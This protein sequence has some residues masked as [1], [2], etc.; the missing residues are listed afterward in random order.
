MSVRVETEEA[1]D[2]KE[3]EN[4][5]Q[6]LAI[7]LEPEVNDVEEILADHPQDESTIL[8]YEI[9]RATRLPLSTTLTKSLEQMTF[10]DLFPHGKAG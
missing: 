5:P 2:I 8:L 6:F 9:S 1:G 3:Q 4:V 7:N 10:L